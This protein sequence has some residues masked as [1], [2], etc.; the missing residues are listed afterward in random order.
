MNSKK[1]SL[2]FAVLATVALGLLSGCATTHRSGGGWLSTVGSVV[3]PADS[4]RLTIDNQSALMVG[5]YID[6]EA[7]RSD[8]GEQ[9]Y[10]K[11]YGVVTQGFAA[12]FG[13]DVAITLKGLC[14]PHPK[15]NACNPGDV[16]ASETRL[17]SVWVGGRRYGQVWEI[18][19]GWGGW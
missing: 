7:V 16:L 19:R 5:V 6:G 15:Q 17:L 1:S 9:V 12:Y 3:G 18:P 10:I 11:P 4:L 13:R 14:P 8:T 2:S